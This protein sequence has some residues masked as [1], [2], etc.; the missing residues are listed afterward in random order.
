MIA[1]YEVKRM[2]PLQQPQ[3]HQSAGVAVAAM[4]NPPSVRMVTSDPGS[5][6]HHHTSIPNSP[7]SEVLSEQPV[8]S[9]MSLVG[10][11]PR[12]RCSVTNVTLGSEPEG[13]GGGGGGLVAFGPAPERAS[14]KVDEVGTGDGG[15][16]D[17]SDQQ[18]SLVYILYFDAQC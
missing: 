12:R 14:V 13:S 6:D 1:N 9:P 17:S 18:E 5:I 4:S 2:T 10:A 8:H 7:L 11:E 15:K 16:I 3:Q